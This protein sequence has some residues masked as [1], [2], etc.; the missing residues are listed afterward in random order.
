MKCYDIGFIQT[1]IDGELSHDI[2]KEFTKHL[3]TCEPCQD[4]LIQ[5]S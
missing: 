1:Y 2:R 4:L 3:D 5:I